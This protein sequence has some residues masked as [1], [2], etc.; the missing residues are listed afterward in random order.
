MRAIAG[1]GKFRKS[2]NGGRVCVAQ[3]V[4][5]AFIQAHPHCFPPVVI[6]ITD[7]DP[8]PLATALCILASTDGV[9]RL[10]PVK[11]RQG[12]ED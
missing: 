1:G 4:S 11:L 2:I 5:C 3:E 6:K 12:M 10:S 8:E 9:E 7:G